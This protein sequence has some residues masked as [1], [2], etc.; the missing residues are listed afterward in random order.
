MS[1]VFNRKVVKVEKVEELDEVLDWV[2]LTFDDGDT[3]EAAGKHIFPT[4]GGGVRKSG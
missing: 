2:R 4:D 1:K 3:V